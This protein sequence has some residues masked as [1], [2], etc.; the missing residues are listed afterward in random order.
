[1]Q[2]DPTRDFIKERGI[3][4]GIKYIQDGVIYN[5]AYVAIGKTK[6]YADAHREPDAEVAN[7][8]AAKINS[9]AIPNPRI[10]SGDVLAN[11]A[12]K[13]NSAGMGVTP[14]V[15]KEIAEARREN[16]AAAAAEEHA[17]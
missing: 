3:G 14:V 16:A 15:P 17:V 6:G 4:S 10:V 13:L 8:V 1:M 2:F 12:A 11:A 9:K 5:A 7:L